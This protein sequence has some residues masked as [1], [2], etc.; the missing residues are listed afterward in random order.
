MKPKL[1]ANHELL[2][3]IED[4]LKCAREAPKEQTPERNGYGTASVDLR[5]ETEAMKRGAQTGRA[6]AL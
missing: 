2:M 3:A 6:D 4:V 1:A 5:A